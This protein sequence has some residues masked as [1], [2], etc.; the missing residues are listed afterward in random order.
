M[1]VVGTATLGASRVPGAAT[2]SRTGDLLLTAVQSGVRAVVTALVRVFTTVLRL[3]AA[4]PAVEVPGG[5]LTTGLL[6]SGRTAA[7]RRAPA[8]ARPCTCC[9]EAG[10]PADA[11]APRQARTVLAAAVAEWG[12]DDDLYEDAAM[13]VTELV[14]NA[15]D[16][17]RTPST[18]TVRL[19]EQGL[20]IGVRDGRRGPPPRPR[21][22]DPTA[23]R[24]RGLQMIDALA[25][26]WGV[27]EDVD[28][29]TVWA[30]LPLPLP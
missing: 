14:A 9:R 3:P 25:T 24:G 11:T 13:V 15:V 18:L 30:V 16:H 20:R 19:E 28:G 10:L 22:V 23:P 8:A 4:V 17:A 26:S 5:R 7:G 2:A 6:A 12:L 29:K 27:T 21:P 1:R